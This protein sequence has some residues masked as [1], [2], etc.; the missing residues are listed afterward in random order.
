[1]RSKPA[2]VRATSILLALLGLTA[3]AFGQ[4]INPGTITGSISDPTGAVIPGV[5]VTV[6]NAATGESRI[7]E[8]NESGA[9][10]VSSIPA[11]SYDIAAELAGFQRQVLRQ[12]EL[13]A[14]QRL[15]ANIELQVGEV[16]TTVEVTGA[17][18]VIDTESGEVY[19]LIDRV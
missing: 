1:M 2:S 5:Q 17:V 19:S 10:F 4:G 9:Y 18:P 15:R 12:I 6:T 7:V 8:P 13:E 3:S 14:E 16:T 11:G